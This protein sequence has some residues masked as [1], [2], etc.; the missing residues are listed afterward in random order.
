[1]PA[2]DGHLVVAIQYD[3]QAFNDAYRYFTGHG[4]YFVC[5]NIYSRLVVLDVFENGTIGPDLAQ[6]WES[7]DNGQTWR[8]YLNPQARWHD[9]VP[10]TA[11][12]VAHTYTTVLTRGYAGKTFLSDIETTTALDDHTVEIRL[13]A[14]NA[15][16]LA[17]LGSFVLTHIVPKH[18]FPG[19]DWDGNPHN[20]QPIG[21]GPFR[22]KAWHPGDRIELE[23]NPDYWGDGPYV[24]TLT[25]RVMPDIEEALAAVRNGEVHF[26]TRDVPC[27]RI[28]EVGAWPGVEVMAIDGHS[29]G[30]VSFNWTQPLF[31]DRRVRE[32]I[33][34]AIDRRPIAAQ[35][36]PLATTPTHYYLPAVD[37]AFDETAVAPEFDPARAA[38]L[39]DEAGHLPDADGVRLRLR[40][41]YRTIYPH[42]GLSAEIMA[43]QLREIG[44]VLEIEGADPLRW[45]EGYL[46]DADFDLLLEA[47]D[48]GPDPQIM[49]SYLT[50][51]DTRNVSRYGNPVVDAAFVAG[52][53]TT[54][55]AERGAHYKRLQQALAADI[56]RV[57]F[58]RHGEH[59]PF[60]SEFTGWSWS[61]GVRGSVPF[62]YHGLVRRANLADDP[63]QPAD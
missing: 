44:I 13:H 18:L 23:A 56:A 36:C 39:L 32:A 30:N 35:V 17:Q 47:G 12:D 58:L 33:A 3:A 31:Q 54:D 24:E 62:W 38:E 48:I 41:G 16:F 11:H 55:L 26:V 51:G 21:S 45:G 15:A 53:G 9:G 57:P 40:M 52:R 10:V 42:Y 59:L 8:F 22:F 61:D 60:R 43:T 5:N 4:G 50:S 46:R 7:P 28:D 29:M 19:D 6:R 63:K 1:M 20:L 27:A 49:A 2:R 37:W 34:R 14:P 25:Y